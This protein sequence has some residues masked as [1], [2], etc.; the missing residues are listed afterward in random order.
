MR[1]QKVIACIFV[2]VG[3]L[4]FFT[5]YGLTGQNTQQESSS[6]SMTASNDSEKLSSLP[7]PVSADPDQFYTDD[8]TVDLEEKTYEIEL[9]SF[10]ESIEWQVFQMVNHERTSRGLD[11]L[12]MDNS[13]RNMAR[14]H[15]KDMADNNFFDHRNFVGRL[16]DWGIPYLWAAENIHWNASPQTSSAQVAVQNWMASADH[17]ANI[18]ETNAK[19]TGIGVYHRAGDGRYYYTQVFVDYPT[20]PSY[21]ISSTFTDVTSDM[22]FYPYIEAIYAEG[23]T[24]GYS[25]GTY[26]PNDHVNRGQM[27]AFL[28]RALKLPEAGDPDNPNFTD[29]SPAMQ[30]YGYIEAIYAEGI[31][32]GYGDGT[33]RPDAPVNREQM[34]AFIARALALAEAGDP[35]NPSFT[36]VSPGMQFFPYIEAIYSGGI[37]TGYGDGTYRPRDTVTRGQMAAFLSRALG[38]H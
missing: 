35:D 1:F 15:S 11:A 3:I 36:D 12:Q 29:V 30:F 2:L 14:A 37:T 20:P 22:Q 25:D 19:Y 23:I 27:A 32:T 18:L 24:T 26:R 10:H 7:N 21:I 38:L 31:T 9:Y 16:N 5:S 8:R 6:I 4:L 17:Q 33:Y 34:A 28:T 13:V